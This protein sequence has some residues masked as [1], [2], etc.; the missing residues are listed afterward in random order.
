M[1]AARSDNDR[2][3]GLSFISCLFACC[4][5]MPLAS[6]AKAQRAPG[7]A[8]APFFFPPLRLGERAPISPSLFPPFKG[9]RGGQRAP[10]RKVR[11][12]NFVWHSLPSFL[13]PLSLFFLTLFSCHFRSLCL[14]FCDDD[15]SIL[16]STTK[17]DGMASCS[18]RKKS[19][20]KVPSRTAP[21]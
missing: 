1:G 14:A 6:A 12:G 16:Y 13:D 19:P 8:L 18:H 20:Y 9:L 11:E 17:D 7:R 2:L 10:P 5:D 3:K 21:G 4:A 15:D